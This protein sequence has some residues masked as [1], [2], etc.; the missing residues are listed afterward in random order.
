MPLSA[1]IGVL[2]RRARLIARREGV[3][4]HQALD[5]VARQEGHAAW[6]QLSARAHGDPSPLR[7]ENLSP[8]DT[9][10]LAARPGQGKTRL[11]L[12]LLLSAAR[13]GRRAVLFTLEY[14][15]AQ[16]EILLRSLAGAPDAPLPQVETSGDLDAD[17]I[18]ARLADAPSG[19]VAAIDYLQL[20]D[21]RRDKL[22]L[23]NQVAAL[24]RFAVAQGVILIFL[25]QVD[26]AFEAGAVATP[27]LAD[28]RLPNPVPDDA[29]SKAGFLHGGRF[30]LES[31][32]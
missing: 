32:P 4:L 27:S 24:K 20:L 7:L 19:A 16:A 9:L 26:R 3:P 2:K 12:Q 30:R 13:A 15:P 23:F 28:I 10:L 21:Q 1:P 11:A 18:M 14:T 25:S 5:R 31:R 29:F 17:L 8:G 22:P 6:S